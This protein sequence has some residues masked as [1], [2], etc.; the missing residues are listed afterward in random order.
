MG[1][2]SMGIVSVMYRFWV[3]AIFGIGKKGFQ[4]EKDSSGGN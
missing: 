4:F 1:I 2:V 3:I